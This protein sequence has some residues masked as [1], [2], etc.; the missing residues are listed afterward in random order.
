MVAESGSKTTICI[1]VTWTVCLFYAGDY[2]VICALCVVYYVLCAWLSV[3]TNVC[4][5]DRLHSSIIRHARHTS[6]PSTTTP[7][8]HYYTSTTTNTNTRY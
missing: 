7:L 3:R 6:H 4:R 5:V 8:L 2:E 1:H